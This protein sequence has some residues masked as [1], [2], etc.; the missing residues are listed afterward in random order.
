MD[1]F[2]ESYG[3]SQGI[4]AALMSTATVWLVH[5]VGT[6]KLAGLLALGAWTLPFTSRATRAAI[7]TTGSAS[8]RL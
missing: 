6:W 8:R 1:T 4:A 2:N 5:D 7:L 3:L